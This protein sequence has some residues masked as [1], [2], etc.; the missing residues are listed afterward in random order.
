MNIESQEA[1]FSERKIKENQ[2]IKEWLKGLIDVEKVKPFI[3]ERLDLLNK[4]SNFVEDERQSIKYAEEIFNY[5]S[6][7]LNNSFSEEEKQIIR[8]GL[9]FSDIGKTGPMEAQA[10]QQ[11]LIIRLFKI[12]NIK[13]PKTPIESLIRDK[14]SESAEEDI[15]L[16]RMLGFDEKM[17]IEQLWRMHCRWSK[18]IIEND[19]VPKEAIPA[20]AL[21]HILEGDNTDL[22]D[23]DG[24]FINQFGGSNDRF[25]RAEKLVVILDKYDAFKSRLGLPHAEAVKRVTKII[26]TN[27]EFKDDEEFKDLIKDLDLAL[28]PDDSSTDK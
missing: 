27:K 15:R 12:E 20:V 25:D 24:K 22:I 5:R 14:F 4:R 11:D 10:G 21:H 26:E 3:L 28:K 9:I 1:I 2:A 13:D 8:I 23:K 6:K 7:E 16:F 18:E 17:P 19:G